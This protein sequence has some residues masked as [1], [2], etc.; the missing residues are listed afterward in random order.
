MVRA[1]QLPARSQIARCACPLH[2]KCWARSTSTA[3]ACAE[4]S[5]TAYQMTPKVRAL[6][7]FGFSCKSMADPNRPFGFPHFYRDD[8]LWR[9]SWPCAD[10]LQ[11]APRPP[12]ALD[13]L[14]TRSRCGRQREVVSTLIFVSTMAHPGVFSLFICGTNN[15]G[16]I[17]VNKSLWSITFVTVLS[18]FGAFAKSIHP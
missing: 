9:A 11:E 10:L 17:P 5:T 6:L 7:P 4:G 15:D 18:S 13:R 14:G 1:F 12:A 3:V 16:A 8:V 2:S